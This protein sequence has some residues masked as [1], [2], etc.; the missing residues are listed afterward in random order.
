MLVRRLDLSLQAKNNAILNQIRLAG[1]T[2]KNIIKALKIVDRAEFVPVELSAIA[3]SD[4]HIECV[5]GRFMLALHD[6]ASILQLLNPKA[7][8]KVLLVG[9]NYGYLAALLSVMGI[10]PYIVESS[11]NLVAKCHEKLKKYGVINISNSA[12]HLGMPNEDFFDLIIM[13]VGGNYIPNAIQ[14]QLAEGGQIAACMCLDVCKIAIYMKTKGKL[15]LKN[16]F[17][18][19]IL[20]SHEMTQPKSFHF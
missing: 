7:N 1:L 19:D 3:Y 15:V 4:R 12:L 10:K 14:E 11:P 17:P 13:E 20:L 2:N 6:V 9:G 16:S 5:P 18:S 8:S